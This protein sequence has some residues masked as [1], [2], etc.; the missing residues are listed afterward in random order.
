M[1]KP[2]TILIESNITTAIFIWQGIVMNN[3]RFIGKIKSRSGLKLIPPGR[4]L[5][6]L[7]KFAL[8]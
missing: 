2:Q 7:V 1:E 5:F 6:D 4:N 3:T 8:D